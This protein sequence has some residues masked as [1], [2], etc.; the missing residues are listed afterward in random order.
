MKDNTLVA[1]SQTVSD[2]ADG[3]Y[4][5]ITGA[6]IGAAAGDAL[7]WSTEFVRGV[8]HLQTLYHTDFVREYRPWQKTTGG[9]FN[10]YIDYI[11][12]GQYS[13]DTQLAMATARSLNADGSVD[14]DHFASV[15]LPLWLDYARGAGR[16]VTAAARAMRR[17]SVRWNSNF[18]A[19]KT[20]T[21]MQDYRDAGA[22]GAAMRVG[23]LALA[24]VYRPRRLEEAVWKNAVVTHGHPRAI[25]GALVYAEALR[26]SVEERG[27]APQALIS[28]LK[29]TAME[30]APPS[31]PAITT[32]L[33]AW[34]QVPNRRFEDEWETVRVEV[35]SG[36]NDIGQ[37]EG[38][39]DWKPL[40]TKFGC[41]SPATKGSGTATV[42]GALA[43]F[44]HLG[45][46]LPHSVV[47]AVNQIGTDTDTIAGFVGGLAGAVHGF[48]AIPR[49][50]ASEL[51]DYDY[52]MRVATELTAIATDRG[53]GG[54]ALLPAERKQFGS[55]PDLVQ[56]LR[57]HS[58]NQKDVVYHR[59]FG[60][61]V[62]ES[63]EAQA[64]RRKDGAR[65][66]FA[67]VQFY[68]GQSCKFRYIEIP[69]PTSRLPAEGF[70]GG[71]TD[72]IEDDDL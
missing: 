45:H 15:E 21:G 27:F 51:Q 49:A 12:K 1:F 25:W 4:P 33:R 55:L 3:L 42:L 61:G 65:A 68:I 17:K 53:L 43:I 63:V 28:H 37:P 11:S 16:T 41:F 52:L 66:V 18:F 67:W 36:L 46:Q 70:S 31:D 13:D 24:N 19:V 30:L 48:D 2:R 57:S 56:L 50:W 54:K 69:R 8:R 22:N 62:V 64:L 34:D 72:L 20:R 9:R 7:G 26:K 10:A 71:K 32:W 5:R 60:R 44:Y 40:L 6:L 29:H 59:L 58:V 38:P 47:T 35:L 14:P 39:A 23:P